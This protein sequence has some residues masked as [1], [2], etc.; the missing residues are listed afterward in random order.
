LKNFYKNNGYYNVKV[1][2]TFAKLIDDNNFEL[3][4][5]IDSGPKI[6]FGNLDLN[7][8]VDFDENNFSSIKKLFKEIRGKPYSINA[9]DKILSEIDS[10]TALE[11][12]KFIKASV[13]ETTIENKMN[14]QFYVEEGDKFYVNRI[15]VLGNTLLQKT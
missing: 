10:V 4:F 7:L 13:T 1:N 2:S 8:P 9:I 6:Y 14:L 5:N 11:Q 3:I 12:Y 15:N